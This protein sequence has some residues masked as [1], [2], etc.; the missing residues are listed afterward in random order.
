[1]AQAVRKM[2]SLIGGLRILA[3][4][5]GYVGT[6]TIRTILILQKV[7]PGSNDRL[8]R[9]KKN[10]IIIVAKGL[11]DSRSDSAITRHL[12]TASSV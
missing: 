8:P 1:M 10:K 11:A 12:K 6:E 3:E 7:Q 9:V 2:S 4:F 5:G